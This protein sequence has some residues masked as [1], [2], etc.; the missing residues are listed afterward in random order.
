M[1]LVCLPEIQ[2]G[3]GRGHNDV[4]RVQRSDVQVR[5]RRVGSV[6]DVQ[7]RTGWRRF[8]LPAGSPQQ[9]PRAVGQLPYEATAVCYRVDRK[10]SSVRRRRKSGFDAAAADDV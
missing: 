10:S 4:A 8:G 7:N 6:A 9:E 2:S 5:S 3:G 1:T